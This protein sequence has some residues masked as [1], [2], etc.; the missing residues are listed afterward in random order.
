[1]FKLNIHNNK[2][3]LNGSFVK[4]D[5]VE[6]TKIIITPT[7]ITFNEIK[8]D[9]DLSSI[10]EINCERNYKLTEI[11]INDLQKLRNLR[12]NNNHISN[13]KYSNLPLL[14]HID[15][16]YNQ[17]TTFNLKDLPQIKDLYCMH[18][19]LTSLTF[20]NCET[21][22]TIICAENKFTSP[23]DTSNLPNL[24]ILKNKINI[25]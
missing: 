22:T 1:M 23:I 19:L 7:S 21:L 5:N 8:K 3:K 4:N 14:I 17:F 15:I 11:E 12:L 10:Y 18:N 20:E 13:F 24:K 2:I 25:K 16:S 6:I 9:I